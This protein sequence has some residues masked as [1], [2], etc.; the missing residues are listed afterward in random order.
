MKKFVFLL[1][2]IVLIHQVQAQ[3]SVASDANLIGQFGGMKSYWGLAQDVKVSYP[4]GP[5]T[6]AYVSVGYA[7]PNKLKETFRAGAFSPTAE[8]PVIRYQATTNRQLRQAHFGIIQYL[9]GSHKA[10]SGTN[11]YFMAGAGVMSVKLSTSYTAN[12]D[13][14]EYESFRPYAGEGS[15][16]SFSIH[17]GLGVE[18]PLGGNFFW[19]AEA[20]GWIP[21]T[22]FSSPYLKEPEK[23][24]AIL[25]G[26]GI[27]VLFGYY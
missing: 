21:V 20:K 16:E 24:P 23:T 26:A 22:S 15:A 3:I 18:Q 6:S 2:A 17:T 5:K 19:Y 8:P 4:L 12:V 25:I 27:R 9:S 7:I 11:I 13:T 14:A 1:T 10:E